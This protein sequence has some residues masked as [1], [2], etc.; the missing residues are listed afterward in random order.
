M[1]KF[2]I[3]ALLEFL[4]HLNQCYNMLGMGEIRHTSV[5]L[6]HLLKCDY[7]EDKNI[8]ENIKMDLKEINFSNVNLIK[9]V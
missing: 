4:G 5:W 9:L 7:F 6:G 1:M 3:C 8:W 2:M